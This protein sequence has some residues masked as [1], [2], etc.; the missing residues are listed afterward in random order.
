[1][2]DLARSVSLITGTLW[3]ILRRTDMPNQY[4]S[5]PH[6]APYSTVHS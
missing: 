1:M 6:G 4:K 2:K 5:S 3:C